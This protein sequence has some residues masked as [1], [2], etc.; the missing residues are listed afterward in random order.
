M[1]GVAGNGYCAMYLQMLWL[2][3]GAGGEGK[4]KISNVW[5]YL[6]TII[7]GGWRMATAA[8]GKPHVA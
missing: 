1:Y 7:I 3:A 6:V 2:M 8:N 4:K 5:R